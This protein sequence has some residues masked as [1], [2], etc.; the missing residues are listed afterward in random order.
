[1]AALSDKGEDQAIIGFAY[2]LFKD[3]H[4]FT[5]QRHQDTSLTPLAGF[6]FC[7]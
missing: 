6:H 5:V 1:M 7:T 4:T 3:N 2:Q